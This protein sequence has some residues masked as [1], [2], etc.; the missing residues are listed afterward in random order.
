MAHRVT[1]FGAGSWG[2][3]LAVHLGRVGH[4]VRVWARDPDLV[5]T[6]VARRMNDR[7]LPGVDLPA[8]VVPTASLAEALDASTCVVAAVPSHGLRA[9]L[10]EASPA[11]P[12]GVPIVSAAKGLE[13]DTRRRMSQVITEEVGEARP[14]AV[15]SGPSFAVE[16][17]RQLPTAVLVAAA[18]PAVCALV[19][20]EFRSKYFRLYA[21]DDVIGV[22]LGGAL[23][24]VIAI[25][26]GVVE[27]LGLGHN[28]LAGLVT[29]GLAE[30]TRVA[31]AVGGRPETLAGLSGLGDLVLTCTG[32][33]SRNRQVGIELGKGRSLADVLGGMTMVAEGVRTTGAA[34]ALGAE[35][36][37]ELPIAGQ[38]AEVMAGR[39]APLEAV[40]R[41]MLRRQRVEADSR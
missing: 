29:R 39:V 22:E 4:D 15:L 13:P 25:A 1:V 41:L 7:Y 18:D 20:E 33:L 11:L 2:T 34:L 12:A 6:L 31:C 14:V 30:M 3:A 10:R 16:L 19:Q 36:G 8:S 35:Y 5:A 21:S 9:V 40:E 27:S 17:A 38:M 23:K 26:A 24:N 28:A 32:A 37:V